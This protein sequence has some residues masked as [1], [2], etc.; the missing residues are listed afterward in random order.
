MLRLT[1]GMTSRTIK[2]L[3]GNPT[4]P[5]CGRVMGVPGPVDRTT[6]KAASL[7]NIYGP[8]KKTSGSAQTT[9]ATVVCRERE[10]D[11]PRPDLLEYR[12]EANAHQR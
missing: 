2:R 12:I 11:S 7:H 9:S 3:K 4:C 8:A 5:K 6:W 10:L 1:L